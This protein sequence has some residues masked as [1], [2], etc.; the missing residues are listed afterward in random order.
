H[1]DRVQPNEKEAKPADVLARQRFHNGS[2]ELDFLI[3]RKDRQMMISPK[4]SIKNVHVNK[5]VLNLANPKTNKGLVFR[6]RQGSNTFMLQVE[7]EPLAYGQSTTFRKGT[8][9]DSL[10]LL[11]PFDVEQVFDWHTSPVRRVD[12]LQPAWHSHRTANRPLKKNEV[13]AKA[14]PRD[15]A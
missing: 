10:D 12:A 6:L 14:D 13:V 9:V 2:W 3:E 8:P 4:S 5:R 11:K 15:D 7:G 1:F